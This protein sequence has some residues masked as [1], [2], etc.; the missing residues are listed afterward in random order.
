MRM[1]KAKDLIAGTNTR[2]YEIAEAVGYSDPH[3]F[4][5]CFKKYYKMSPNEF[6]EKLSI[7]ISAVMLHVASGHSVTFK[8]PSLSPVGYYL[9]IIQLTS[10]LL[11]SNK[12]V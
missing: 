7:K 5:Y 1:E 3:Y 9:K 2:N 11:L 8:N 6:R 12:K 10:I 4:S